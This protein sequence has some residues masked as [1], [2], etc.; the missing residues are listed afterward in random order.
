[1]PEP[2]GRAR[3]GTV[4]G[5]VL[6]ALG[7]GPL[8]TRDLAAKTG[9][10]TASV[11]DALRRLITSGDVTRGGGYKR[12]T[13]ALVAEP[14]SPLAPGSGALGGRLRPGSVS[15]ILGTWPIDRSASHCRV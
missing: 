3:C 1:M 8:C 13:Y 11:K 15:A 7:D 2:A 10:S 12:P 14:G 9:L 4:A 6:D 5:R